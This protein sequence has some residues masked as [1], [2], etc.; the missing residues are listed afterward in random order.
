MSI[1]R[2][3]NQPVTEKAYRSNETVTGSGTV[4]SGFFEC[5]FLNTGSA[6]AS[7]DGQTVP[8]GGSVTIPYVGKPYAEPVSYDASGTTVLIKVIW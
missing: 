6:T 1:A 5:G 3:V 7:I 8:A 4:D 2:S